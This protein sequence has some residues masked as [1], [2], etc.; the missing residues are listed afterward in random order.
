MIESTFRARTLD[1]G[2]LATPHFMWWRT[3]LR[4]HYYKWNDTMCMF[5]RWSCS[6][7]TGGEFLL[8]SNPYILHNASGG[9]THLASLYCSISSIFPFSSCLLASLRHKKHDRGPCICTRISISRPW[10][11][12]MPQ[13]LC[14]NWK[15]EG[16]KGCRGWPICYLVRPLELL[17]GVH[18]HVA[19]K[20]GRSPCPVR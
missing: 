6:C 8:N 17:P 5:G 16:G 7:I 14:G 20:L 9:V 13:H 4:I 10:S 3:T 2:P 11:Y 19:Y 15:V 1:L 12:H 18:L